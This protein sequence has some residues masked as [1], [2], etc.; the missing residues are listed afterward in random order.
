M[1]YKEAV[2][3]MYSEEKNIKE[4]EQWGNGLWGAERKLRIK[5]T[6]RK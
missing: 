5:R 3:K 4:N 2:G 6:V 1:I